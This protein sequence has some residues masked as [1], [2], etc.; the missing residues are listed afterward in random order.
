M[1]KRSARHFADNEPFGRRT[2][3]L[4]PLRLIGSSHRNR[5]DPLCLYPL[6]QQKFFDPPL[7]DTK[8]QSHYI[9]YST[10]EVH[11]YMRQ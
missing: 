2:I 7:T 10:R 9:I 1:E 8:I 5:D 3:R 4:H 6:P 11:A